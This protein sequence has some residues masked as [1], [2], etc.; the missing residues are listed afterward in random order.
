MDGHVLS[1]CLDVELIY[2]YF[3]LL[4]S[5]HKVCQLL[6]SENRSTFSEDT[7]KRLASCFLTHGVHVDLQRCIALHCMTLH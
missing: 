6:K 2:S 4:Q 7:A 1:D 3:S 5:F